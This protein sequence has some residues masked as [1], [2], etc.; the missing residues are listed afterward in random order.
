MMT[1][2]YQTRAFSPTLKP[3]LPP[4]SSPH[5]KGENLS[6]SGKI[7]LDSLE[8]SGNRSNAPSLIPSSLNFSQTNRS[9]KAVAT[10]LSEKPRTDR[11][12]RNVRNAALVGGT[13]TAAAGG[14][15]AAIAGGTTLAVMGGIGGAIAGGLVGMVELG[16]LVG[17]MKSGGEG[18]VLGLAGGAVGLVGGAIGGGVAGAVGGTGIAIAGA[19]AASAVPGIVLGAVGGLFA[20]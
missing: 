7:V 6:S 12:S 4:K 13:I 5:P 3:A 18:A 15:L 1:S 20:S 16:S 11:I 19:A 8:Q 14:Y 17:S 2:P 9:S 10:S